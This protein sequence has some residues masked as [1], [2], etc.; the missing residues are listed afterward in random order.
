VA[1]LRSGASTGQRPTAGAGSMKPGL[2]DATRLG[3]P[4]LA[5]GYARASDASGMA[6]ATAVAV[7]ELLRDG[8]MRIG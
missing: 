2:L 1:R 6:S 8:T 7:S 3:V 5:G 4:A